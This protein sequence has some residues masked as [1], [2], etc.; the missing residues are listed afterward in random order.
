MLAL[1]NVL[2]ELAGQADGAVEQG[3]PRSEDRKVILFGRLFNFCDKQPNSS[4]VFGLT[5]S[6]TV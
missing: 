4:A 1:Y 3:G 2:T 5:A 6:D